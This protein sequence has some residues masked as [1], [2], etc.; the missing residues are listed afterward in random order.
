[1]RQQAILTAAN[2]I[3]YIA[4]HRVGHLQN[5]TITENYNLQPVRSLFYDEVVDF[6]PGIKMFSANA[7]KGF[8][9]YESILG[10]L[11]E[12][13]SIASNATK[14]SRQVASTVGAESGA[15]SLFNNIAN[16]TSSI[17]SGLESI[18]SWTG[19]QQEPQNITDYS[20]DLAKGI[21]NGTI[22]MGELFAK[23][24]FD[25]RVKNP[26]LSTD[27]LGMLNLPSAY[28]GVDMWVLRGCKLNTREITISTGNVI[29][30]ENVN[31]LAKSNLDKSVS[32][33][34]GAGF[35]PF[36]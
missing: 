6:V 17:E 29:I 11:Q 25:I 2:A 21:L 3:I 13:A 16:F 8:I 36:V 34:F 1:M 14:V 7:T 35:I 31:I 28:A 30:L 12:I 33:T 10:T 20:I 18:R 23:V 24:T 4:D 32:N 22:S 26:M 27:I 9:E 19:M 5:L 15:G